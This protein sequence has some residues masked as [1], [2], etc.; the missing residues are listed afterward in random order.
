[1]TVHE[2]VGCRVEV[3]DDWELVPSPD[4]QRLI[5][6][7]PERTEEAGFRANIVLTAV[8]NGGMSFR[9][10]QRG[11][12]ELMPRQLSM[13]LLVDLERVPVAGREGGRR[14]AEHVVDDNT[15]V[16]MEQWFALVGST[17]YTL[18]ATVDSWRYDEYAD[19]FAEIAEQLS[20]FEDG[21]PGE[22]VGHH[23]G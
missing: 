14:L 12:D 18:T 21:Y 2:L 10:W 13:Y 17:G 9:D 7:E 5:V 19:F 22:A 11:T 6:V 15:P 1:V 16:T 3:P 8:D 20:I 4:Q 23:A